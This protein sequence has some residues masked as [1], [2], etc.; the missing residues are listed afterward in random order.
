MTTA[1]QAIAI[2]ARTC[3][4]HHFQNL[5][6]LLD[7]KQLRESWGQLNQSMLSWYMIQPLRVG[8]NICTKTGLVLM[9]VSCTS[10]RLTE[11]PDAV[12]PHVRICV[13]SAE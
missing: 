6:G 10:K 3:P 7:V 8:K 12:V 1:V 11:E 5:S 13:G 2:K 9:D 4:R